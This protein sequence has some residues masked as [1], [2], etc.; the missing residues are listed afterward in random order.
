M[1]DI[2]LLYEAK[3]LLTTGKIT[4]PR[5]EVGLLKDIRKGKFKLYEIE[6]MANQ[7]EVEVLAARETSPLPDK[8]SRAEISALIAEVYRLAWDW[9]A[10]NV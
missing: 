8:V 4:F 1:H 10:S 3:E 2:R 9:Q 5:P 6:Q 7:L